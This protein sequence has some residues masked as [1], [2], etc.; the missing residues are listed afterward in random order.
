MN[1]ELQCDNVLTLRQHAEHLAGY[2]WVAREYLSFVLCTDVRISVRETEVV[3]SCDEDG[4]E[5]PTHVRVHFIVTVA[6]N[7]GRSRSRLVLYQLSESALYVIRYHMQHIW[8]M[9]LCW[10]SPNA[11]GRARSR[12]I[13]ML[14]DMYG[15][16]RVVRHY[17]HRAQRVHARMIAREI[18]G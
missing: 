12:L 10:R 5:L 9:P 14:T 4:L 6:E 7:S 17:G 16:Q 13:A 11:A 15:V 8:T 3:M 1:I 18:A 2:L